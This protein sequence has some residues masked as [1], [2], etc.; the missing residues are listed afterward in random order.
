[1]TSAFLEHMRARLGAGFWPWLR[2]AIIGL[3]QDYWKDAPSKA[4]L[5]RARL[6]LRE[7]AQVA[8]S[9]HAAQARGSHLW[10]ADSIQVKEKIWGAG[11]VLSGGNILTEKLVA[12]FGLNATK[13]VLDL[14]A[15]LGGQARSIVE[16]YGAYVMGMEQ[17]HALAER[18]MAMSIS[19][20]KSKHAAIAAYDPA[21]FAVGKRYDCVISRELFY[22]VADK[23]KFFK[24]ITASLKKP[25]GQLG[26]VDYVL[27]AGAR[28]HPAVKAWMEFEKGADPMPI[29]LMGQVWEKLGFDLRV[30]EDRTT[31]YRTGIV[32]DLAAFAT[33]LAQHPPDDE[34]K[35]LVT[36]EVELW[37]HRVAAMENGLKFYRFYAIRK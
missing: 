35:P 21:Q 23:P 29:A 1:M 10:H 15:G 36:Q 32:Q 22:R 18:G 27:E 3:A 33:F 25:L 19:A 6:S 28:E 20:G 7:T 37:A 13:T 17:D 8:A 4:S 2:A 5:N 12:P 9:A 16:D 26:F 24:T 30:T 31:K 34:T 11:R 14:A